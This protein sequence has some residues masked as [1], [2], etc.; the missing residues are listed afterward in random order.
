MNTIRE[1]IILE[2]IARAAVISALGSPQEYNTNCGVN[3]IRERTKID[4][5]EIPCVIVWPQ[6]EEAVNSYGRSMHTM[7]VNVEGI[8]E[9]GSVEPG[10]I[11]EQILGDLIKCFT[12][13]EWNR[14]R[15]LSP[16]QDDYIESI[17]YVGGATSTAD[18]GFI[19]AGA[20][21]RFSI[22]YWTAIGDPYSQG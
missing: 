1:E 17:A 12:S 22:I 21:A 10:V 6:A 2:L 9:F 11:G 14:S 16:I 18:D 8:A 5:A 20:I 13:P 3:I 19:T 7:P 15:D 4:P